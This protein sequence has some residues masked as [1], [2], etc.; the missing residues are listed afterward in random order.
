M[1]LL[2]G[3]IGG[4]GALAGGILGGNAARSAARTSA[5]ASRAASDAQ[6]RMYE[7]TRADLQPQR[8]AQRYALDALLS[9]TGLPALKGEPAKPAAPAPLRFGTDAQLRHPAFGTGGL[10]A[11]RPSFYSAG[12]VSTMGG[13]G[14]NSVELPEYQSMPTL[15]DILAHRQPEPRKY[16]GP[17]H[18]GRRYSLSEMGHPEGIFDSA[19]TLQSIST[20]PQTIT[21]QQDGFVAPLGTN[22]NTPTNTMRGGGPGST[23]ADIQNHTNPP[24]LLPTTPGIPPDFV[25]TPGAPIPGS[26]VTENPGGQAGR[27]NFMTDPGYGFRFDEG[28]RAI[29]R[30]AAARGMGLSGGI[31]RELA[32]YGQG[33]GSAE[34]GNVYNRL[35]A[36]AGLG[37]TGQS[38]TAQAGSNAANQQS[39]YLQNIGDASAA[40][41]LGRASAYGDTL[42]QLARLY[43]QGAFSSGSTATGHSAGSIIYP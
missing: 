20:T 10:S 22:P 41:T 24:P 42:S 18:Q 33:L 40:G 38:L 28:Q 1:P 16:G 35:S 12:P 23:Y 17:I 21:A 4:I 26:S 7:Q 32:R 6:M 14:I 36:I 9:M 37:Q 8:E 31:L 15:A 2:G 25:Q 39:G 30:S 29:E 34:Y 3:I 11:L 43:G 19:G 13:N 5:A 27:Y